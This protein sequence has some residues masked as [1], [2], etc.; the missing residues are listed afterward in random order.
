MKRID[1]YWNTLNG[2][3]LL[4]LPLSWLYCLIAWLRRQLYTHSILKQQTFPV[5]VI[6]V[7]NITVGG[8]GKSPLVIWLAGFLESKGYRPG[9][10]SRGYGGKASTWPQRVTPESSPELV[11]DEPVMIAR[12]TGLPMWV[13]PDRPRAVQALL[14][15]SDCD[16]IISDDGLQHYPLGRDLEIVVMD[17]ARGNGN[18]F[19]LPAGPLREGSG[20]LKEVDLVVVN[21]PSNLEGQRMDLRPGAVV[22]LQHPDQ[23]QT[24]DDFSGRKIHAL[25]GIGNPERFFQILRTHGLDVTAHPFGDHHR[26]R[27]EDILPESEIPVLM[28]EKDAVKCS[29]FARPH[30][31]YLEVDATVGE[32]FGDRLE[33]LLRELEH[34]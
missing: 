25:A 30:H 4:L 19:C 17:G 23:R 8:T 11:G 1:H 12:R 27:P 22:N 31:W 20:R 13:G 3:S 5:P 10:V 14:D 16:I 21:G 2:V 7:G 26:F 6:V 32:T 29:P 24:L 33:S 34:G 9:I 15:E 18:G 28:T